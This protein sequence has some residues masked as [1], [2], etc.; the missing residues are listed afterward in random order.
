MSDTEGQ[1]FGCR[2][3][4]SKLQAATYAHR[5]GRC[6]RMGALSYLFKSCHQ[7]GKLNMAMECYGCVP[8]TL[9]KVFLLPFV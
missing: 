9:Q 6:G 3:N 5:A 4:M 7:N 1:R 2:R 8:G